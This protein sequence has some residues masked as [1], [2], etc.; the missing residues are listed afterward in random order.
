MRDVYEMFTYLLV[1]LISSVV[2]V[3]WLKRKGRKKKM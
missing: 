3:M 2:M 1:I